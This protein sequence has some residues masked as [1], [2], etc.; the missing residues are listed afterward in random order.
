M[1]HSRLPR[2]AA[3]TVVAVAISAMISG[4]TSGAKKT[5]AAQSRSASSAVATSGPA[6]TGTAGPTGAATTAPPIVQN[7]LPPATSIVNDVTK[8][9]S[10]AIT[11]CAA[12]AGGWTASGTAAN[13]GGKSVKYDIT[14]F[15]TNDQATVE[16]FAT[17]SVTVKAG[18]NEKW[19]ATKK[20]TAATTTRCVLRGVG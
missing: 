11:A 14:I 8:R 12:T 18:G 16:D 9:K 19:T 10:V 2:L 1:Q 5:A 15:F 3:C 4:C 17:A 6:S 7:T 20:F 13:T